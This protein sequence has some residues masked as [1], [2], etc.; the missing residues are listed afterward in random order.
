MRVNEEHNNNQVHIVV[1]NTSR[2][3][4]VAYVIAGGGRSTDGSPTKV[5]SGVYSGRDALQP[6]KSVQLDIR[7]GAVSPLNLT[8]DYVRLADG[9]T[10]GKATTEAARN[11]AARLGQ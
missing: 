9:S 7:Q 4:I 1:K 3:P 11:T 8:V 6:G 2:S 5:Y 10:C